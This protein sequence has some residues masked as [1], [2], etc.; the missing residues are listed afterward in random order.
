M[1]TT[2][3]K[4]L[5]ALAMTLGARGCVWVHLLIVMTAAAQQ[6]SAPGLLVFLSHVDLRRHPSQ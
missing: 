2:E 5:E 3:R 6:I 4:C 1:D